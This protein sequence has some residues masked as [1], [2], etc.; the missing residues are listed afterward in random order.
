MKISVIIP[1]YNAEKTIVRAV[2]SVLEQEYKDLEVIIVDDFS[3]D[4][5]VRLI[6][7]TFKNNYKI[8]V[9]SL[10]EN[11]GSGAARNIGV[12]RATGRFLAFLDADDQWLPGKLNSQLSIF[13]SHEDAALVYSSYV[14]R[15]KNGQE[16]VVIP[17][18]EISQFR[19]AFT[20]D[21]CCSSAI[22]DT[23]RTGRLLFPKIRY[24]QD[25]GLWIEALKYGKLYRSSKS[26]QVIYQNWGGISSNKIRI[27]N[28]QWYFF[29]EHCDY[30]VAVSLFL[31]LL[32][33][34]MGL[35]KRYL[36]FNI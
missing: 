14:S 13:N 34:F 25:W 17:P 10:S 7:E 33:G 9:E 21:I 26:P 8:H 20:N 11:V 29:R 27:I 28:K 6:A 24:R 1:A 31:F 2:N 36:R 19:L 30:S 4:G 15:S 16:K 18:T 32:Y 12:R 22:L 35:S 23:E 3:S 5:T